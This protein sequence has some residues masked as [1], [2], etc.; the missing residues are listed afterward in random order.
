[1][2]KSSI[3]IHLYESLMRVFKGTRVYIVTRKIFLLMLF[4]ISYCFF[5]HIIAHM[6][7]FLFPCVASCIVYS[8]ISHHF[9]SHIASFL[10]SFLVILL[11]FLS[12]HITQIFS[13]YSWF[14]PFSFPLSSPC[15]VSLI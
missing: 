5:Y 12:F 15:T 14:A 10:V 7:A 2:L 6:A 3:N 13:H 11:P 1:M 9:V 8:K 4:L